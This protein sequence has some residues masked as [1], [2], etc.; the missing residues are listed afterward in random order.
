MDIQKKSKSKIAIGM[1]AAA[2]WAWGTSLIMGQQIAQERGLAAWV[3]WAVCNSLTLALF[4]YLFNKGIIKDKIYNSKFVKVIA[5]IIQLFCL[6]VQLNFI[7]QQLAIITGSESG[8]I[9]GTMAIGVA[10]VMIV[11]RHG[12]PMSIFTDVFQWVIAAVSILI[13]LG[14]GIYTKC[15]L[16][17]FV[18]TT[19][20]NI[21]WGVWSGLILFAGPI[22]DVQHWQR[23]EVDETKKG[24]YM[25]AIFFGLYMLEIL[26]MALF[27]FNKI[28]HI[29]LLIA[30]MCVTTSTIDSISVALHKIGNKY[31]GTGVALAMCFAFPLFIK[32]GMLELWSSFGVIRFAFAIMIVGMAIAEKGKKKS[33]YSAIVLAVIAIVYFSITGQIVANSIAGA[34][35]LGIAAIIIAKLVIETIKAKEI[36]YEN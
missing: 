28:M 6:L 29:I 24:Y 1:S 14:V 20:S 9:F 8:A 10:F 25:G 15:S 33:V 22:G 19:G 35:S 34:I 21:M 23:A 26:A 5:I 13:I 18:P 12:L 32:M 36:T 27:D 2:S 11:F 31:I 17:T 7:N 4:G 3:I 16:A 30:V